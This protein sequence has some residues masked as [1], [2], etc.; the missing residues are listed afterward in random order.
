MQ[1]TNLPHGETT[2]A[3]IEG[4]HETHNE[5]GSGFHEKVS[6]NALAIVLRSKGLRVA[7]EVPLEVRFRGQ[8]IGKFFTDMVVNE[9]VLVEIKGATRIEPYAEAQLLNYLKAA[10]GGVGLLLNFGRTPQHK[11][12]V[13]GDPLNSLPYVRKGTTGIPEQGVEPS[14][15]IEIREKLPE[16]L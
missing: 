12:M 3:I 14:L 7:I 11:R 8:V 6:R 2:G 4:F 9:T 16:G 1:G 15:V 10:G 13:M 5:L